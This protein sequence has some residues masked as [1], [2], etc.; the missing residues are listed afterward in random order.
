MDETKEID[1]DLRKIL[2]MMRT[3][4]IF[5]VLITIIFGTSAGLYTHFFIAPMYSTTIS[6]CV[7]NNPDRVTTDQT[8]SAGDIDAAQRLVATYMFA[9]KSDMVL[10]QVAK[11]VNLSSASN[12]KSA[13][14]TEEEEGTFAFKV[15]VYGRDP[16]LCVDIANAIAK[17]APVETAKVVKS[18]GI[19]IIDTAKLPTSPVSP[20]LKK[21]I[22]IG[23]AIGF[24]LSFAGFFVYE[25]FDSTITNAKDLEREFEIPVLGTVPMLEAVERN[26]GESGDGEN[27]SAVVKE[28]PLEA[29][30]KPI[31][32]P[33]SALLENIQSMKGDSKND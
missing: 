14:T 29:P 11:E 6:M 32:K 17:I 27:T 33:S 24:A 31:T 7:Y 20:N 9:L 28:K 1:I 21:N 25:M 8:A 15:N 5:I 30:Q 22:L 13:I 26:E 4:M 2:Y 10:D 12:I 18:G 3:K 16:Q 23:L 19:A